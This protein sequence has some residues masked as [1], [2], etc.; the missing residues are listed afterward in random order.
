MRGVALPN[1]EAVVVKQIKSLE[2]ALLAMK[3][4]HDGKYYLRM[5]LTN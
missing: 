2:G 1:K 3:F 5:V 4:N